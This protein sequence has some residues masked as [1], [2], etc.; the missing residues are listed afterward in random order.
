MSTHAWDDRKAKELLPYKACVDMLNLWR[1]V[2]T[3]VANREAH[4]SGKCLKRW[5]FTLLS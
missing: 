3:D 5:Y 2:M 4:Y 1:K